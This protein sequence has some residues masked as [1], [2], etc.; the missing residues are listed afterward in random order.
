[1]GALMKKLFSVATT[2][3]VG[4][5]LALTPACGKD[6]KAEPAKS[7]PAAAAPA[8]AAP[9]AAAPAKDAPAKAAPATDKKEEAPK[10]GW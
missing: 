5:A 1:M 6:K 10:G 3:S 4:L 2:L 8:A 9:A 7:E